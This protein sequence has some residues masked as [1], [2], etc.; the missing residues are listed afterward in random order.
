MPQLALKIPESQWANIKR[1]LKVSIE[2]LALIV[3]YV[4]AASP[5][6]DLED[7]VESCAHETHLDSTLIEAVLSMGISLSRLQR[8]ADKPEAEIFNLIE[9]TLVRSNFPEWEEKYSQAWKERQPILV[10]LLISDGAL[11]VMSKVRELL[12]DFQCL[13]LESNV[14][15]DVRYVYS[16]EANEIKGALVS[17]TLKLNYLEGMEQRELHIK[18]SDADLKK[19]VVQLE[20]GEKKAKATVK[21]VKEMG[22]IE[23]TPGRD[24]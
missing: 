7:M 19:M 2:D 17:H 15:T 10:E 24:A 20:R 23:L 11:E 3:E 18:V 8:S 4:K 6:P 5:S 1:F 21:K 12:Y 22:I 14:I 9:E 13:L 16:G